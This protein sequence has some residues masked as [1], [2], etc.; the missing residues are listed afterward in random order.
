[1]IEII[2]NNNRISQINKALQISRF[3]KE[4]YTIVGVGYPFFQNELKKFIQLCDWFADNTSNLMTTKWSL[5]YKI[6]DVN[7][8]ENLDKF[9][10]VML[11][12]NRMGILKFISNIYPDVPIL[13]I[14]ED[15]AETLINIPKIEKSD[16][17][18]FRTCNKD[19]LFIADSINVSGK[20]LIK[21]N[22]SALLNIGSLSLSF[23]SLIDIES[24]Y[25]SEIDALIMCAGAKL[26]IDLDAQIQ[27]YNCYLG[28]NSKIHAYSG[29]LSLEDVYFGECC[30]VHVYDKLTIGSG[31]IFSWNVSILD[32]DG[33]SLY[34][35]D[36]SNTP[37]GIDIGKNVWVGNGVTIL[38]GVTIGEGSVIAAG[39]VVTHSIPSHSL[40]VGNP[41]KVIES[42][43]TWEYNY[44][45]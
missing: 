36:K 38:K 13:Q 39:S 18:V 15:S 11:S 14:F 40:A 28:K 35:K 34:Y 24:R 45:Y 25:K 16:L 19:K 8:L 9:I 32:G 42:D 6:K 30:M 1:M 22:S 27:I 37:K 12:N 17:L 7:E 33:H 4:G 31:S 5:Q 41:A 2:R 20:S 44:A 3:K 43:I 21:H 29:Q 26:W 10:I 23:G